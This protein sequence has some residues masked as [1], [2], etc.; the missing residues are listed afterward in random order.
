M[1]ASLVNPHD[2]LFYPGQIEA[3]QYG[4]QW[5]QG[6]IELPA[7]VDED[8]SPTKPTVQKQFLELFN[9][10]P[11]NALKTPEMK[12]HYLN[13]YGNLM[14]S[15]D[16]YLQQIL[17][18]LRRRRMLD[19]TLI[20]VTSDHGEMD[21]THGGLRQKNFNFYEE[22]LRVPLVYSNPRLFKRP[23]RSQALVSHVDFLPTLASLVGAPQARPSQLAGRRLL[24]P[25]PVSLAQAAAGP[26]RVHLRRLPVRTGSG[27]VPGPTPVSGLPEPRGQHPRAAIQAGPLPRSASPPRRGS[28]GDVRPEVRSTR[29][30]Q[31]R[32]AHA[33]PDASTE[34]RASPAQGQAQ[35][36]RGHTAKAT[37]ARSAGAATTAAH[38]RRADVDHCR[39]SL[40][41]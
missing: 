17:H 4:N 9:G 3:A 20:I 36:R 10:V 41:R 28:V 33:P 26:R 11:N 16:F 1:I 37:V 2:V 40:R 12:R 29:D 7:T 38:V 34:G 39:S 22:T 24:R 8:L 13:F 30:D 6:E 32:L 25:D 23:Q 27:A 19:N 15:S 21:L 5:L 31:H 14:R 18:T 35:A